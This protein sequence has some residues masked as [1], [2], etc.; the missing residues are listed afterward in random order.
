MAAGGDQ[1]MAQWR[2]QP[3]LPAVPPELLDFHPRDGWLSREEWSDARFQWLLEHPD[4]TIDGFDVAVQRTGGTR[5]KVDRP[6]LVAFASDDRHP[7]I[8]IELINSQSAGFA[9]P[10]AAVE[11]EPDQCFVASVAELFSGACLEQCDQYVR[12]RG[13]HR[14]AHLDALFLTQRGALSAD[15]AR[16]RVKIR[17]AM[18]GID[19]LHPHRFRHTFAHDFLMSGGQERDLKRLAGWSSDVSTGTVSPQSSHSKL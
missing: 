3:V 10:Y 8:K 14:W 12:M 2:Q 13:Q 5:P 17:G 7:L 16:E 9:D 18:A 6:H 19:A 11:Q 1:L 15:G 4:R